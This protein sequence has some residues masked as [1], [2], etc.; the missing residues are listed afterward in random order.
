MMVPKDIVVPME[1]SVLIVALMD[2]EKNVR[3]VIVKG[4]ARN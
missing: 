1:R 3:Q 2:W 4:W